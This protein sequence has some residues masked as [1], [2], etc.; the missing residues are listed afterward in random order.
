MWNYHHQLCHQIMAGMRS[1]KRQ[2]GASA[3]VEAVSCHSS[4][5]SSSTVPSNKMSRHPHDI[6]VDATTVP[7][8]ILLRELNQDSS[9]ELASV[10]DFVNV[11]VEE[12]L[13]LFADSIRHHSRGKVAQFQLIN[14]FDMMVYNSLFHLAIK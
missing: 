8:E 6:S 13:H 11:T 4:R 12:L 10:L 9:T 5:R 7:P 3:D 2:R 14:H 1:S